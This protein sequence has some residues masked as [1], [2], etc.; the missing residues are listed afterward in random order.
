MEKI[1]VSELMNLVTGDCYVVIECKGKASLSF[2]IDMDEWDDIATW[3]DSENGEKLFENHESIS[4][5]FEILDYIY[6]RYN[7]YEVYAANET[8]C[9]KV[10]IPEKEYYDLSDDIDTYYAS[11]A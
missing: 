11:K 3:L 9:I 5:G 2:E 4:T 8:T 6:S 10:V 1:T 7:I